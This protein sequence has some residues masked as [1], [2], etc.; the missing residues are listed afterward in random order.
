[1]DAD[2]AKAESWMAP[3]CLVEA[4]RDAHISFS[5][6][7]QLKSREMLRQPGVVQKSKDMQAKEIRK[8]T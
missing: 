2:I 3:N 6:E 4:A 5:E 8:G 7:I 1:M